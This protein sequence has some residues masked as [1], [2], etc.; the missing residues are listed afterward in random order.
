MLVQCMTS[1]GYLSKKWCMLVYSGLLLAYLGIKYVDESGL[2]IDIAQKCMRV[3]KDLELQ[4]K[5]IHRRL[6]WSLSI[7]KLILYVGPIVCFMMQLYWRF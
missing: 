1:M 7:I 2:D 5:S 4:L 6:V 3:D